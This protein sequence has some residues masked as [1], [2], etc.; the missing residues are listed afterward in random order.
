VK[1]GNIPANHI[2][3]LRGVVE[4]ENAAIGLLITLEEPTKPMVREAASSGFYTSPFGNTRHPRIQILTIEKLFEGQ[5]IDCPRTDV[6]VTFKKARRIKAVPARPGK[7]P[8][9]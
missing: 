9:E 6:N 8:F 5:R 4:R 2:R 3:E 1:S 7:L